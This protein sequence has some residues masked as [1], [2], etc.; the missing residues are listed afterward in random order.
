MSIPSLPRVYNIAADHTTAGI[1]LQ[2]VPS[3][4]F[5]FLILAIVTAQVYTLGT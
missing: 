1:I 5:D 2:T 3:A 4:M